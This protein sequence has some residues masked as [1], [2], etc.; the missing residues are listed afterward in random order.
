MGGMTEMLDRRQLG[1]SALRAEIGHGQRPLQRQTLAHHFAKQPRHRFV[2]QRARVKAFDTVQHLRFALRPVNGAGAFQFAD[3]A[4]VGG[5]LVEQA[6]DF[7][8]AAVG[9]RTRT[10]RLLWRKMQKRAFY[11]ICAAAPRPRQPEK[12]QRRRKTVFRLP[13]P[14]SLRRPENAKTQRRAQMPA[15]GAFRLPLSAVSPMAA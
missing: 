4:G 2:G 14:R 12:T 13:L 6:E 15:A 8:A 9:R 5:A 11:Y 1:E 7:G 10:W 3:G